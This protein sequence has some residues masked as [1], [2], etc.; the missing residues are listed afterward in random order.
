MLDNINQTTN[1][2]K[3]RYSWIIRE[4]PD[5]LYNDPDYIDFEGYEFPIIF[6]SV[7]A[8]NI[9][10][11]ELADNLPDECNFT[12]NEYAS[13]R[14]EEMDAGDTYPLYIYVSTNGIWSKHRCGF[15]VAI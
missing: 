13:F 9:W 10:L 2:L 15:V 14:L 4:E 8:L 6:N 5:K 7:S 3:Q 11:A 12:Y 1:S